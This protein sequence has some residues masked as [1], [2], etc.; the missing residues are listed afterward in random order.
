MCLVLCVAFCVCQGFLS[1]YASDATT[2]GLC[3]IP[4]SHNHH[5]HL[6]QRAGAIGSVRTYTHI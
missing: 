2:G 4:R 3:V 6:S 5:R 1:L